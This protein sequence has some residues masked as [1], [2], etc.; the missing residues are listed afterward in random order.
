MKYMFLLLL[1]FAF[2]SPLSEAAEEPDRPNVLFIAIDDL[3]DWVGFMNGHPNVKTPN[4]DRLAARSVVF[5]NAQCPAPCCV[6]SRSAMFTGLSPTTTGM[7]NN[8]CGNF[9]ANPITKNAVTL[10]QYFMQHGY[11][12]EGV[13]KIT[14][15]TDSASWHKYSQTSAKKHLPT[16]ED[17][18]QNW[19]ML[20]VEKEEM[21]D[22]KRAHWTAERIEKGLPEPFFLACGFHLPHV[23]W[24][25]PRAYLEQF[26]LDKITLPPFK[27]DDYS[28]IAGKAISGESFEKRYLDSGK[29]R[30]AVQGYLGCISFVDECVGQVIDAIEQ[31]EYRDNTVIVLWSDHGMHVGEKLRYG[32]F[33]LW[34]ESAHAPLLFSAQCCGIKPG[35]CDEVANLIDIYPTLIDLC[36]L[37]K[38]EELE[39][40][41]LMPQLQAPAIVRTIPSMTSN[42]R[43]QNTLRTKRWRYIRSDSGSEQLYDHDNDPNEWT[44]L[45]GVAE[46]ASVIKELS[47][48]IPKNQ[49]AD[50]ALTPEN[51]ARREANK[52]KAKKSRRKSIPK[53]Q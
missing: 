47:G 31:S 23:D 22:W 20:D 41:T 15:G 6:P 38:R 46:Y 53:V 27:L 28:D 16:H 21:L 33:T 3:N 18:W 42:R 9:R 49:E 45:A 7:Y 37:P 19:G 48:F 36:K 10:T 51:A 17:Y 29:A 24:H 13:G 30:Q 32:K 2:E 52:R 43:Y 39:G 25:A 4:M 11:R 8:G 35:Q 14:H 50:I 44:N 34:E 40:I 26:P 12:A 5:T 1:A